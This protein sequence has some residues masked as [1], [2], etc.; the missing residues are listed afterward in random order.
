MALAADP[1][2]DVVVELMGG[3]EG[4][5][6]ALVEASL[7]AGKPV[8]TANKALLAVHGRE[9]A[10]LAERHRVEGDELEPVFGREISELLQEIG[11]GH[12]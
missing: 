8:V 5:A 2:V 3:S 1:A 12:V 4:A 11:R 9:L 6:R 10:A 7:A